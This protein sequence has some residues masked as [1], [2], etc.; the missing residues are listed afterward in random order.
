MH[1]T[2]AVRFVFVPA[3]AEAAAGLDVLVLVE[4]PPLVATTTTTSTTASTAR[5]SIA[6]RARRDLKLLRFISVVLSGSA[7]SYRQRHQQDG[8]SVARL[9]MRAI[10]L[11]AL[12]LTPEKPER[13]PRVEDG[14]AAAFD[15]HGG[16]EVR[17]IERVPRNPRVHSKLACECLHVRGR[18]LARAGATRERDPVRAQASVAR[19]A[20]RVGRWR[21]VTNDEQICDSPGPSASLNRA[22]G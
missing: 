18:P 2:N 10:S 9:I 5:P 8:T 13:S 3:A 16:L 15:P 1:C 11:T 19:A 20:R 12:S 7:I 4:L 6:R 17:V 21:V 22:G 14:A